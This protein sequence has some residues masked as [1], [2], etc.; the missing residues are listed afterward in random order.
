MT[1][2]WFQFRFYA[3]PIDSIFSC[4]VPK[5]RNKALEM[6]ASDKSLLDAKKEAKRNKLSK[7]ELKEQQEKQIRDI[8]VEKMDIKGSYSKP[9]V[10]DVLW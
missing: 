6:I 2:D 8:I 5:Y 1:V 9:S 10:I 3:T 7:T 4:Q